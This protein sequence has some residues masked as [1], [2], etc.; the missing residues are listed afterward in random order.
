MQQVEIRVKGQ[1]DRCW[2]DWFGGLSIAHSPQGE[3]MLVGSIR[4]QA[5]LRGVLFR[6]T[7]LGLELVS[8][9]TSTRYLKAI[10]KSARGGG[11]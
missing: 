2:S 3:T 1:I 9:N 11:D 10:G 6:L 7:D 5:E 8:I 4:D